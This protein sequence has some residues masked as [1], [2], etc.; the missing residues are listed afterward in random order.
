MAQGKAAAGFR[1]G[2]AGCAFEVLQPCS[3]IGLVVNNRQRLFPMKEKVTLQ[4][5]LTVTDQTGGWGIA[6]PVHGGNGLD[7]LKFVCFKP[8]RSAS[9]TQPS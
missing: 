8:A 4:L 9:V 5:P 1:L 7:E 6:L 3:V 2:V